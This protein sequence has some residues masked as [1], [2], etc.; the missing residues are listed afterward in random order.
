MC[1]L[2]KG[3]VRLLPS[4][5]DEPPV[6]WER[7]GPPPCHLGYLCPK[8]SPERESLHT[9]SRRNWRMYDAWQVA[10]ATHRFLCPDALRARAY[11]IIGDAMRGHERRLLVYDLA[12]VVLKSRGF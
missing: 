6:P 10:R 9:L 3:E 11:R 2:D 1:D 8:E 4:G 5:D 12:S 7:D